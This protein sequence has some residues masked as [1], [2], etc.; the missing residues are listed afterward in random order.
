MILLS[1]ALFAFAV[2]DLI[3]WTPERISTRR[4]VVAVAGSAVLTGGLAALSGMDPPATVAV[5]LGAALVSAVWI[6]LQKGGPLRSLVWMLLVLV[7]FFAA[8]GGPN[9]ID[10]EVGEWYSGLPFGFVERVSVDQFVLGLSATL[11]L[12]ASANQIVRLVLG[13]AA[14]HWEKGEEKLAGGRVLGPLERLIV[15]AIVLAGDPAAAA[16]VVA[17]K[18]LLRFPD[19]RSEGEVSGPDSVTEYFLIGTLTSLSVAAVLAVLVLAAG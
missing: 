3:R 19:L 17:A 12:T 14:I 6:G 16:I 1:L 8:S 5:T 15:A 11:F 9:P 13:A 2:A 7:L 4:A 18:G 10:G